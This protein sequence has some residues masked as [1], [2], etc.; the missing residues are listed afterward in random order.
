M[1][2]FRDN[3]GI[4]RRLIMTVGLQHSAKAEPFP[5][6]DYDCTPSVIFQFDDKGESFGVAA[7]L[8]TDTIFRIHRL[9]PHW[10]IRLAGLAI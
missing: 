1:S 3:L 7:V 8:S 6:G 10:S 5:K 4:L 9:V 2:A